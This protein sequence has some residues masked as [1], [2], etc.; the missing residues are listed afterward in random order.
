MNACRKFEVEPKGSLGR[1]LF[2]FNLIRLL[3][4]R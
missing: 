1:T 4:R 3:R 2:A